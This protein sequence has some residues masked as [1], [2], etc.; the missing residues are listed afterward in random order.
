MRGII[1]LFIIFLLLLAQHCLAEREITAIALQYSVP[2]QIIPALQP[3]LEPDTSIQGFRNQLI[4]NA[5]DSELRK[6]KKLLAEL[7]R[8]PRQLLISLKRD[9]YSMA[10]TNQGSFS[11]SDEHI[12]IGDKDKGGS[13]SV[14]QTSSAHDSTAQQ[15]VRATEGMEAFIASGDLIPVQRSSP[16]VGLWTDF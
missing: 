8:R 3:Y 6:I 1:T 11:Y 2:E 10:T 16:Y 14:D 5:S 13:A 9:G 15:Q 4:I 7:D 12:N